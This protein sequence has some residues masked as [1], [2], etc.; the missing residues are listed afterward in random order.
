MQRGGAAF[1]VAH[2][3][4]VDV[5][6]VVLVGADQS[7]RCHDNGISLGLTS[8]QVLKTAR[9]ITADFSALFPY[10]DFPGPDSGGPGAL[11]STTAQERRDRYHVALR[12][13]TVLCNV[14]LPLHSIVHDALLLFDYTLSEPKS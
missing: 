9:R 10:S 1:G 4:H 13:V 3:V 7:L 2:R 5:R 14:A 6:R 8:S 12:C 11:Q